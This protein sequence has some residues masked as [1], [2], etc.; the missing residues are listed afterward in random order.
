MRQKVF[1][2][3]ASCILALACLRP[4]FSAGASSASKEK[5]IYSFQGGADGAAPMSDLSLDKE[6]NL[7]GTTSQ[8]GPG[9]NGYDGCGTVFELENTANG[10]KEKVLYRFAGGQ[11]GFEPVGGVILDNSGNLYGTTAS[12][13]SSGAGTVFKLAPNSKGG[14]TK[15]ILFSF[16]F[17]NSSTGMFPTADLVF[18]ARG[19]LYG[20]ASRGGSGGTSCYTSGCGAV[21]E[22]TPQSDGSWTETTIHIFGVPPNG[23]TPASGVV[24]DSEG[25][26]YG[27]TVYGGNGPCF[28][29]CGM[30]YEFTP[31]STGGWTETVI[32]NFAPGGGLGSHPSS[33]IFLGKAGHMFGMTYAGGD[34]FGAIYELHSQQNGWQQSVP[35]IFYGDPGDGAHPTGGLVTD[36]EGD[37]FGATPDGKVFE[38]KHS[39]SGWEEVILH[40]FTG[41]PDGANPAAG[42]VADSHNHLYG[43][44]QYGGTGTGCNRGCGTVYE[45]TH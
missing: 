14:W 9:C 29:G 36:T 37:L 17:G 22:L 12:G 28:Q 16:E 6:G 11:D 32:Y 3:A 38:L 19:N 24:L 35:H 44:T 31:N 7:Y 2:I 15:S 43:T 23:S 21:F 18:D 45:V 27:A 20:T 34:G 40:A 8:G 30:V 39:R 33:E 4:V 5:V 25:N 10:W 1:W 26:L 41:P 42:L 13:G